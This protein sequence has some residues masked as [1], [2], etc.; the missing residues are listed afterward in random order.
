VRYER[1]WFLQAIRER[2]DRAGTA[3]GNVDADVVL[4]P[5]ADAELS[6]LLRTADTTTDMKARH[7]AGWLCLART[8]ADPGDQGAIHGSMAG[9]LLFP[10]WVAD[11]ELVPQE[12]AA[13]YASADP[14]MRPDPA[15]ADRPAVWSAQCDAWVIAAEGRQHD[16]PPDASEDVRK[17]Y[18]LAA[19][20]RSMAPSREARLA[21]AIGSGSL[22][23]LGTPEYD[24][25]Y[26]DWRESLSRAL[27][28]A[29]MAWPF[30]ELGDA[31][32]VRLAHRALK[33]IPAD[34]PERLLALD[35]LGIRL[36]ERYMQ[37]HAPEDLH[38]AVGI[39]RDLL[40][41]L[42]S[43]SPQLPHCLSAL[44][45]ALLLLRQREGTTPEECDEV[46]DV[47]R[48]A[49]PGNPD[50][51]AVAGHDLGMALVLRAQR[52]S[53]LE[54]LN[55]AVS[56]LT[57]ALRAARQPD[58]TAFV[59]SALSNAL[60]ARSVATGAEADLDDA[61]DLIDTAA[62]DPQLPLL[63]PG[64]ALYNRYMRDQNAHRADLDKALRLLKDAEAH[65]PPGHPDR[66]TML[67]DLGLVLVACHQRSGEPEELNEAVRAHRESVALTPEGHE[68]L[69][70]RLINLGGALSTRHKL[71]EDG[72]DL[73]EAEECRRRAAGHGARNRSGG[74]EFERDQPGDRCRTRRR[75]GRPTR[76]GSTAVEGGGRPHSGGR[77]TAAQAAPQP[78]HCPDGPNR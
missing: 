45:R 58:E 68:M 32:P 47:F 31:D 41:Q 9:T 36:R 33:G 43:G 26:T 27:E 61:L 64:M 39:A 54:D 8:T 5:E 77:P 3:Y 37:S 76:G 24:P 56:V 12:L 74:A 20:L 35:G 34:S 51:P 65:L 30:G 14:A 60:R 75:S 67:N 18:E 63:A 50:G 28:L 40:A 15:N 52:T 25:S 13:Y 62:T 70:V 11:P 16:P 29:G 1:S 53:R 7:A 22:A 6:G 23:V 10:V 4:G 78:R 44:A 73:R 46:V 48:R 66:P 57:E 42:P 49:V 71:T 55:E 19:Q 21:I 59:R 17:L 72:E 2:L 69:G 38:E